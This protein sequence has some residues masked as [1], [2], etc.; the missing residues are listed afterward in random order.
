M[1]LDCVLGFAG[2]AAYCASKH[3]VIGLTRA[4]AKEV[5]DRNIRVNASKSSPGRLEVPGSPSPFVTL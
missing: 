4:A 1:E 5:G 3:A 2:S